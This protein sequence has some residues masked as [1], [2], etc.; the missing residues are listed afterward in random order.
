[1][2]KERCKVPRTFTVS[3]LRVTFK[4]QTEA[5]APFYYRS[6]GHAVGCYVNGEYFEALED[7]RGVDSKEIKA[8]F[9]ELVVRKIGRFVKPS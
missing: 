9:K 5:S 6:S 2:K 4:H 1:M 7:H 8:L 3:G